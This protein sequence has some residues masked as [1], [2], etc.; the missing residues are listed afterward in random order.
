MPSASRA[1][2]TPA[3]GKRGDMALLTASGKRVRARKGILE[4]REARAGVLFVLPW[5]L[6]LLVFTTYPVIASFYFSFTD[7]SIVQAPKW[8]G[9]DNYVAMFA[10]DPDFWPAV[11]NSA[12]Y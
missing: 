10:N 12:Y 4:R 3:R 9:M 6:S 5:L 7:Y 1:S 8:V 2:G 11:R